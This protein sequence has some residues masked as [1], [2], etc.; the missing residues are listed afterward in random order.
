MWLDSRLR[1]KAFGVEITVR[2]EPNKVVM[3]QNSQATQ[4]KPLKLTHYGTRHRSMVRY[5]ATHP[6]S[7]GFIV[8]QDGDVR[9]ITHVDD[10]VVFW[11]NIR[12]QSVRN[13]RTVAAR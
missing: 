8:S 12:I 9:A 10:R 3:A 13:A 4:V 5:C 7:V 2:E 1:L 6:D 11:D